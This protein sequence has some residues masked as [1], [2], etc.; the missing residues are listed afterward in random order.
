[1]SQAF[2]VAGEQIL[3]AVEREPRPGAMVPSQEL[4]LRAASSEAG[5]FREWAALGRRSRPVLLGPRA[6][7]QPRCLVV[8]SQRP[9]HQVGS[10]G[11]FSRRLS[12]RWTLSTKGLDR[13]V[14]QLV[15]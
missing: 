6:K 5:R 15:A 4:T 11:V 12:T 14:R 3:V 9:D 10:P 1:M 8:A 13:P 7:L 2:R